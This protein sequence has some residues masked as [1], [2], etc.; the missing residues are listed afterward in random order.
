MIQ[1]GS[2]RAAALLAACAVALGACGDSDDEASNSANAQPDANANTNAGAQ[3]A[4]RTAIA[5]LMRRLRRS[6]NTLD[7]KAFCADLSAAAIEE[8]SGWAATIPAYPQRCA[9]FITEYA[10]IFVEHSPQTPILVRRVTANGDSGT[11]TMRGGLAG[12]RSTA[13][14]KVARVG[15][16]WKLTNPV[17]GADTRRI[18]PGDEN[19]T[20]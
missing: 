13:T 18:L 15:R 11:I 4:D 7:G 9:P 16:E 10:K 2:V 3:A 20:P 5:Q 14:Y 19:L 8:M 17:S 6:Y 12:I 1:R